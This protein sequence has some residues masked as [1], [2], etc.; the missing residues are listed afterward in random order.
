MNIYLKA[1]YTYEAFLFTHKAVTEKEKCESI[2]SIVKLI[3]I[4]FQRTIND[5]EMLHSEESVSK[6]SDRTFKSRNMSQA[7]F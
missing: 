3:Y 5:R 4:F 1:S 7:M 6:S 2:L